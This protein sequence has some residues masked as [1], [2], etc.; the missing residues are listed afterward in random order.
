MCVRRCG[1]EEGGSV[2]AAA[3]RKVKV[4]GAGARHIGHSAH[5]IHSMLLPWVMA[6]SIAAMMHGSIN[7][8]KVWIRK[9]NG[10]R[11]LPLT[12]LI[13]VSR[14]WRSCQWARSPST[15]ID[16]LSIIAAGKLQHQI[17]TNTPSF[18]PPPHFMKVG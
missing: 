9:R 2:K 7:G 10:K 14:V 18:L 3:G 4:W 16:A 5:L 8:H 1:W 13:V 6:A 11:A 17:Q 12:C 15:M